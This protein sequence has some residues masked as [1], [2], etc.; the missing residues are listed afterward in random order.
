MLL[1]VVDRCLL[2]VVAVAVDLME[3]AVYVFNRLI[4]A[5]VGEDALP[6]PLPASAR[7]ECACWR[8]RHRHV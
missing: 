8:G 7:P 6:L 2:L 3:P 5:A 1:L 4:I